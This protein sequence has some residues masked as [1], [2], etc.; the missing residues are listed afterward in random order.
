MT[1]EKRLLIVFPYLQKIKQHLN[2]LNGW[3]ELLREHLY[4]PNWSLCVNYQYLLHEK[5]V[6]CL[7][8]NI[9]CVPFLNLMLMRKGYL[10]VTPQAA[11]AV[12]RAV[13]E[14]SVVQDLDFSTLRSQLGPLIAVCYLLFSNFS[15]FPFLM[16]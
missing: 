13:D 9:Q 3:M 6:V 8:I 10:F 11:D 12:S 15:S 4:V 5:L 1:L 2:W 14:T 7:T 16:F